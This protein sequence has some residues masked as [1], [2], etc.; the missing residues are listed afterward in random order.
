MGY[1]TEFKGVLEIVPPLSPEQGREINAF[2]KK[3][4]CSSI[5][6]NREAEYA[7]SLHCDWETD[8]EA[9]FWNG[10]EKSYSMFEWL[11]VLNHRFFQPWGCILSGSI[12]AVGERRED[13]WAIQAKDGLLRKVKGKLVFQ[14][15]E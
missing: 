6:Q 1:T 8:G 12:F 11:E 15:G 5:D 2:C 3:R 4:H 13:V 9:L 7:P 10:M 14:E